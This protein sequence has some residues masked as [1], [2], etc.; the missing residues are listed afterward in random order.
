MQLITISGNLK[1]TI[2]DSKT[3]EIIRVDFGKNLILNSGLTSVCK[4]LAGDTFV[5]PASSSGYYLNTVVGVPHL[6]RWVQFGTNGQETTPSD[7]PTLEN[8]TLDPNT[9][10]PTGASDILEVSHFY[11]EFNTLTF[12]FLLPSNKG[13]GTGLSGSMTYKEVVLMCKDSN[14]PPHFTWFARRTFPDIV[15]TPNNYIE[16]EWTINFTGK[17]GLF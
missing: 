2:K 7:A 4:L 10:T 3:H 1:L 11:P 15:K 5:P 9:I 16:G 12:Q 8:G 17:E 6:P 13:N 14:N